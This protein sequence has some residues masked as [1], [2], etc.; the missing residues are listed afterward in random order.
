MSATSQADRGTESKKMTF[1]TYLGITSCSLASD[2][3]SQIL[4]NNSLVHFVELPDN[5]SFLIHS[6]LFCGVLRGALEMVQLAVGV[7]FIQDILKGDEVTEI[8][9]RFIRWIEDN[10]PAREK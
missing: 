5:H 2:K 1:K 9:M 6:N 4:E 8:R 7:K 3:F 10:L